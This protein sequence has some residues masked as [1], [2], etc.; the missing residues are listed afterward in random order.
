ML[1]KS[2]FL[3]S[4]WR[5]EKL[6][7]TIQCHT[8][9]VEQNPAN[10][11]EKRPG[12]VAMQVNEELLSLYVCV[13][14][15]THFC[16]TLRLRTSTMRTVSQMARVLVSVLSYENTT[17][18]HAHTHHIERMEWNKEDERSKLNSTVYMCVQIELCEARKMRNS[19]DRTC[20]QLYVA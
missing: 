18:A 5:G 4:R 2:C 15:K 11:R 8:L 19:K 12:Q 10:V 17:F 9:R 14:M 3:R 16:D 13:A 1:V 6:K 20:A 7:H